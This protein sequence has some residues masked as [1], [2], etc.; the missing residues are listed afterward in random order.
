MPSHY[1]TSIDARLQRIS[2]SIS[3]L[4]SHKQA[5]IYLRE[6]NIDEGTIEIG[7]RLC[8]EATRMHTDQRI[9]KGESEGATAVRD[10]AWATAKRSH[11]Q[12]ITIARV[13]LRGRP[14]SSLGIEGSRS[15]TLSAWLAQA[16]QLHTGLEKHPEHMARLAEF[17]ITAQRLAAARAA[18][19]ALEQASAA[20]QRAATLAQHATAQRNAALGALEQ[21]MSE[22]LAVASVALAEEPQLMELLG[23]TVR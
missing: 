2:I 23:V 20:Q 4:K 3:S 9:L 17:G 14:A 10:I 22:L 11:G 21:W 16:R 7:R 12:I 8:D 5:M 13:A 19:D 15:R 1:K 18:L 6:Y